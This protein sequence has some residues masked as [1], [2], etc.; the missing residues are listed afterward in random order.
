[1]VTIFS[2]SC[3]DLRNKSKNTPPKF[4]PREIWLAKIF[5]QKNSKIRVQN[6]S[7]WVQNDPK[8]VSMLK[9]GSKAIREYQKII[10]SVGTERFALGCELAIGDLTLMT[11]LS[12][13][14]SCHIKP[15]CMLNLV[16]V[17]DF[18]P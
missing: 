15:E 9:F 13:V 12:Y 7:K 14:T 1:M 18:F 10:S 2:D 3:S 6:R 17:Q 8:S 5:G 11:F 16:D 4:F